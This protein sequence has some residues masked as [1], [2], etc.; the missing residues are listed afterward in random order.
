MKAYCKE[1]LTC[2][3]NSYIEYHNSSKLHEKIR[4]PNLCFLHFLVFLN[5][6]YLE[7]SKI[8]QLIRHVPVCFQ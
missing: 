1:I 6:L 7:F 5:V 8:H 2:R 4:K 3:L